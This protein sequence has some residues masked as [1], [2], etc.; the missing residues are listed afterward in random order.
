[1][2][3][4]Q[5]MTNSFPTEWL[6]STTKMMTTWLH[7]TLV[8]TWEEEEH[9]IEDDDGGG[10]PPAHA[11]SPEAR[12]SKGGKK[13]SKKSKPNNN[14]SVLAFTK[15]KG[16][17]M[18]TPKCRK[19]GMAWKLDFAVPPANMSTLRHQTI[20]MVCVLWHYA[21]ATVV[22][23]AIQKKNLTVMMLQHE[24]MAVDDHHTW[25]QLQD[26]LSQWATLVNSEFFLPDKSFTFF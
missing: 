8:K 15:A 9:I 16:N 26:F 6:K 10:K 18:S 23:T 20:A 19:E 1:M 24:K 12:R 2:L 17:G 14:D 3:A 21:S 4:T 7:D 13:K 22:M 11:M 25:S 5:N